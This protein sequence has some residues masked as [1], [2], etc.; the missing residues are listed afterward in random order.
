M[1]RSAGPVALRPRSMEIA[2]MKYEAIRELSVQE[3][4]FGGRDPRRSADP[5][6]G[7]AEMSRNKLESK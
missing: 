4:I 7:K 2:E 1:R 6:I 5:K 3:K